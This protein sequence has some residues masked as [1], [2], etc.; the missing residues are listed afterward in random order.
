MDPDLDSIASNNV[1]HPKNGRTRNRNRDKPK[2]TVSN[3]SLLYQVEN[4]IK[5]QGCDIN[6]KPPPASEHLNLPGHSLLILPVALRGLLLP[7]LE[8]NLKHTK[9]KRYEVKKLKTKTDEN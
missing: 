6:P 7:L 2:L 8:Y 1:F 9:D 5:Q 3:Q 4:K